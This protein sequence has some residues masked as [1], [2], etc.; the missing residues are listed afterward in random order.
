M[1]LMTDSTTTKDK[2]LSA[3]QSLIQKVG[4][5]VISFRD[6]SDA[7]GIKTASI[8]YYFPTK[9]DLGL[10]LIERYKESFALELSSIEKSE[11]T[12][13]NKIKKLINFMEKCREGGDKSCLCGMFASDILSLPQ[14]LQEA[15]SSFFKLGTKWLTKT[16]KEGVKNSEFQIDSDPEICAQTFFVTLQ[17]LMLFSRGD[18]KRDVPFKECSQFLMSLIIKGK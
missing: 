6:L 1:P 10:A 7:V 9:T 14:E 11:K 12:S 18:L 15:V 4:F 5:N 17:G 16:I 2:L 3:A 13:I 8:H